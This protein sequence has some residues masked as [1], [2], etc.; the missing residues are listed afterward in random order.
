MVM[1]NPTDK[2]SITAFGGPDKFL[3]Q[4]K[5]LLGEQVFKG[6]AP[7]TLT[8]LEKSTTVPCRVSEVRQE[9]ITKAESVSERAVCVSC[10][11][12]ASSS[13][14]RAGETQSEGGFGKDKVSKA[15]LLG[16]EQATDSKGKPY[17]KYELLTTAGALPAVGPSLQLLHR[18]RRGY[19]RSVA[20]EW[21][22]M[23]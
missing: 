15:A 1:K 13:W 14:F 8:S 18:Q 7:Q 12:I 11:C 4:Y 3:D 20:E 16:M 21:P 23:L 9:Q 22:D 17:Y 10:K 5:F 19:S 6:A 2:S